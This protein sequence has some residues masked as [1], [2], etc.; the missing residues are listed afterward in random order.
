M[1]FP[2]N[3]LFESMGLAKDFKIPAFLAKGGVILV[4]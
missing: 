1:G 3:V 2:L 4:R